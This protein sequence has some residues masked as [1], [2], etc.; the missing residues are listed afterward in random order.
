LGQPCTIV[1]LAGVFLLVSLP[2][3]GQQSVKVVSDE[4]VVSITAAERPVA[5][6]QLQPKPRKSYFGKLFSPG[7]VNVLRDA[8][9]DHLH[10]HGL[11][12]AV[13]VDGVDFWSENEKCGHQKHAG[14]ADVG[15]TSHAGLPWGTFTQGVDWLGPDA[16]TQHLEERRTIYCCVIPDG[17]PTLLVWQADLEPPPG[18][19][20]VTLSGST[21]FGLGMRFVQS[22]DTGGRFQNADGKT[23]VEGTNDKRSDW[24][25]YSATAD[26]KP[27]TVAMFDD[28]KNP[29][30]PATWFTMDS[31]FAYLAATL[32]LSKEPL[33][34]ESAEPVTLRYVV[35]VWDGDVRQEKIG[36]FYGQLLEWASD[37]D[38][39]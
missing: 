5:E 8:P 29:R 21:Y 11:M 27:V 17:G 25:T 20:S 31:H 9:S 16:E 32:N 33:V 19:P 14:L 39:P 34:I 24:C 30:H 26:G 36:K 38:E 23:G 28:P 15:E 37:A 13:A 3:E 22:M 10:H 7:G 35:A 2:A 1:S 6:Y 18:K 12:F 4:S